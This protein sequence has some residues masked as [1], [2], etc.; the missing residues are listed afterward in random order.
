MLQRGCEYCCNDY[1]GSSLTSSCCYYPGSINNNNHYNVKWWWI[2]IPILTTAAL[3][4]ITM[5][6]LVVC[7]CCKSKRFVNGKLF[8]PNERVAPLNTVSD[9]NVILFESYPRFVTASSKLP[10]IKPHVH[11][12][13]L[14][15]LPDLARL[16]TNTSISP[17]SPINN[18]EKLFDSRI[19][20]F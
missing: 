3:I 4:I 20:L 7:G 2:V 17:I 11:S 16:T 6:L 5:V 8:N 19:R 15:P 12:F 18:S 13:S 1:P 10:P 14:P 9:A